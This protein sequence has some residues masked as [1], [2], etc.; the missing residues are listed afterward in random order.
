MANNSYKIPTIVLRSLSKE[1]CGKEVCGK[2]VC[3]KVHGNEVHGKEVS[4][5]DAMVNEFL[6]GEE[7][8]IAYRMELEPAIPNEG[9]HEGRS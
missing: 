1:I 3:G 4:G 2:E 8:K 7:H 6:S 5:K 9:K